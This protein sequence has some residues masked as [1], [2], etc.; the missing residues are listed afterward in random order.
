M[1]RSNLFCSKSLWNKHQ[2]LS[3]FLQRIVGCVISFFFKKSHFQLMENKL[4]FVRYLAHVICRETFCSSQLE[5]DHTD[6]DG[7]SRYAM[8]E[9]PF[10][11]EFRF[12]FM[13]YKYKYPKLIESTKLNEIVLI[14]K[15]WNCQTEWIGESLSRNT[16]NQEM[17]DMLNTCPFVKF[18]ASDMD[19][20]TVQK[21]G[22]EME[23]KANVMTTCFN[24]LCRKY[25]KYDRNTWHLKLCCGC[26]VAMYCN[27]KCQKYHWKYAH[28]KQCKWLRKHK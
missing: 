19:G 13:A 11:Q 9:A 24:P 10:V 12:L 7:V 18:N 23:Y 25:Y 4:D 22:V 28:H 14:L 5:I 16:S 17:A 20:C 6:L 21:I 2:T 27:R 3:L 15:N 8:D 1:R 26:R